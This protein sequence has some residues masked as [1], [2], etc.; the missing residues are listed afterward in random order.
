MI[1]TFEKKQPPMQPCTLIIIYYNLKLLKNPNSFTT[2]DCVN[3]AHICTTQG[4]C[5]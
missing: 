1:P 4:D 5:P 2:H 3:M